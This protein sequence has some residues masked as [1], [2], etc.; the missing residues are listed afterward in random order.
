MY[1]RNCGKPFED[2]DDLD[3]DDLDED[4]LED[5]D[6]EDEDDDDDWEKDED[7]EDDSDEEEVTYR[8][9]CSEKCCQEYMAKIMLVAELSKM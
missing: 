7:S 8:G 2:D 3:D 1:C 5:D 6:F 4:D 9:F